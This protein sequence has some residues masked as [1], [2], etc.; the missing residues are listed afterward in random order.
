MVALAAVLVAI[1]VARVRALHTF[2][3]ARDERR[4]A[5]IAEAI[6]SRIPVRSA[7]VAMQH[8]GSLHYYLDRPVLR[9]EWLAPNELDAALDHLRAKGLH[10]YLLLDAWEDERFRQRF[11][12]E[13]VVGR[14]D[15]PPVIELRSPTPVRLYDPADRARYLAGVNVPTQ[16]VFP[17]KR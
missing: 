5:V 16:L 15:W 13:S 2:D 12:G 8:T 6:A 17:P 4:Y 11:A 7:F 1:S 14:L 9:W 10:P 3:L